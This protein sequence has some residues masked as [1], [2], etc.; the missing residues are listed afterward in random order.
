MLQRRPSLATSEGSVCLCPSHR[1]THLVGFV[2]VLLVDRAWCFCLHFSIACA[3]LSFFCVLFAVGV[4]CC[5]NSRPTVG[6]IWTAMPPSR[7][8]VSAYGCFP[9]GP[10]VAFKLGFHQGC[11]PLQPNVFQLFLCVCAFCEC[12]VCSSHK[13]LCTLLVCVWRRGPSGQGKIEVY[14]AE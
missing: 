14:V 9:R 11:V 13:Q 7:W 1:A 12:W 4:R 8:R 6:P 3:V 10:C 2:L 5:S